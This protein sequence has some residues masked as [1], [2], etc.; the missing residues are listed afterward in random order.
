LAD[1]FIK[2]H[3]CIPVKTETRSMAYPDGW[4]VA[5]NYVLHGM[6]IFD[7]LTFLP[8]FLVVSPPPPPTH[9]APYPTPPH[10]A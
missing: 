5:K 9:T 7:F 4:A 3:I 6:F 2:F 1:I 8:S 10:P